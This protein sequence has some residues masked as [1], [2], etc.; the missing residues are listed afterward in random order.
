MRAALPPKLGYTV[1]HVD[2]PLASLT[3]YERAFGFARRFATPANDYAELMTGETTL[4]F[5]SNAG[6]TSSLLGSL[7]TDDLAD[8][9]SERQQP[10]AAI[11]PCITLVTADV[12]GAVESAR[13]QGARVVRAVTRNAW[14][15]LVACVRAPDGA[16]VELCTPHL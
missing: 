6:T 3:F 2:D 10:P 1:L 14:G 4:A 8:A 16:L 5:A 11:T 15:Q 13:A 9:H 12:G 7:D